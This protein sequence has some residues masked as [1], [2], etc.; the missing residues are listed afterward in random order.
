ML[1]FMFVI[2]DAIEFEDNVG[3]CHDD[4]RGM[5]QG[6][7]GAGVEF[8]QDRGVGSIYVMSEK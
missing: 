7:D 6:T 2:V 4:A 1:E 3:G 5:G 8:A